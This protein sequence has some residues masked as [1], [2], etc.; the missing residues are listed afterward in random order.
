MSFL[1]SAGNA[2]Q[3]QKRN[4]MVDNPLYEGPIY[5]IISENKKRKHLCP[6]AKVHAEESVYLDS[7]TQSMPRE[8]V[9]SYSNGAIV[10]ANSM[11]DSKLQD[12]TAL[13]LESVETSLDHHPLQSNPYANTTTTTDQ[14][15]EDA[16]TL[17]CPARPAAHSSV[18]T[19]HT[20][21]MVTGNDDS[22][23]SGRYVVDVRSPY[24]SGASQKQVTLV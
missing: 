3:Q 21:Y 12:H 6:K 1:S 23:I 13:K 22:T 18:S 9:P 5:E 7:P 15:C 4:S 8:C 16:Y 11:T 10:M 17:M 19:C 2:G 14:V 24:T 20:N